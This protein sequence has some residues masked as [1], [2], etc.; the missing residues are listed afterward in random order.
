MG[1][2]HGSGS[3]HRRRAA[4]IDPGGRPAAPQHPGRAPAVHPAADRR[5][6]HRGR[7]ERRRG[8]VRDTA[9]LALARPL[10]EALAGSRVCDVNALPALAARVCGNLPEATG[11]DAVD[12]GG[13]RGAQT[14]GKLRLSVVS[15]FEVACLD[16]L[17]KALGLP[18][19]AL[20]GG[21][22]RGE[23]DYSAYLFYRWAG[24]PGGAGEPDD[25]APPSIRPA[26]SPRRAALSASTAS[27]RSSS[28]AG[29]SRPIRRSPRS[30]PW[31][32]PSP[33][34]RC[35][36]TPTAPGPWRHP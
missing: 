14:A 27:R 4:H 10:A 20:L 31:P 35:G 36:S 29:S 5:D 24:D 32:T 3:D 15:A 16:A 30:A 8:D 1:R 25:W 33:A 13:L 12:A 19:H 17:G 2:Q 21:K 9:Y 18:V 34:A 26:S 11:A 23:V 22:V 7:C 28:R 6:R